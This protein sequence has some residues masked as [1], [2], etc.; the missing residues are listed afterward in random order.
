MNK[1]IVKRF[2]IITSSDAELKQIIACYQAVFAGAP[3]YE[4]WSVQAVQSLLFKLP[5][6]ISCWVALDEEKIVGFCWGYVMS[7]SDMEKY[8]KLSIASEFENLFGKNAVIAYQSDMGLLDEYRNQ[9][10]ARELFSSR[11]QDFLDQGL[12]VALVRTRELPEPSVTHSWFL[13][14]EKYQIL[15]RHEASDGRCI[16]AKDLR[17]LK[18]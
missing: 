12:E 8:L 4:S 2:S 14:K 3:W 11:Q 7:L 13:Y 6:D 15:K 18:G 10:V 9:G 5:K 17:Q 1:V 16:L